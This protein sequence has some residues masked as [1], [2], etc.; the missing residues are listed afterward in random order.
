MGMT[1]KEL[2]LDYFQIYDVAN[3]P[4]EG[5]VLLQG[6]FDQTPL[7]M[8]LALLDFFANPVS[9][10]GEPIYDK[11]AHLAWYRGA[12]PPETRARGDAGKP[13]RQV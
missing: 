6:Q 2:R 3:R 8:Q 12:Q 13:V 9:K 11:N 7:K 10:N 1:A 5:S 4:A